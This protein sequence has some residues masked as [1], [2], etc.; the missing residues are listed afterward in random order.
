MQS[1]CAIRR[2]GVTLDRHTQA[3][4]TDKR[5]AQAAVVALLFPEKL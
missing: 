3:V 2:F 5:N 1:C 4:T